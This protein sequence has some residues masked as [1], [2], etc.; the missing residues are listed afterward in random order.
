MTDTHR[1]APASTVPAKPNLTVRSTAVFEDIGGD[2]GSFPV[3]VLDADRPWLEIRMRLRQ[4]TD[5]DIV[6]FRLANVHIAS[7]DATE[8]KPTLLLP[9]G[10]WWAAV[11]DAVLEHIAFASAAFDRV[12]EKHEGVFTYVYGWED[13]ELR[14]AEIHP[15]DPR[16][17]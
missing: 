7:E 3:Q 17:A 5:D 9:Q 10:D 13:G 15:A 16:E 1:N 8:A 14:E 4:W 6:F 12:A 2:V 11:L